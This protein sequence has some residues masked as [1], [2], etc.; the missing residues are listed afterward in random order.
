MQ[1]YSCGGCSDVLAMGCDTVNGP[2]PDQIEGGLRMDIHL[3]RTYVSEK[4]CGMPNLVGR[5]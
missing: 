4:P 1:V 2:A 3:E 5:W